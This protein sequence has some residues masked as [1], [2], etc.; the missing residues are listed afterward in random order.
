MPPELAPAT[1]GFRVHSGWAAVVAVSGSLTAPAV[2]GRWRIEMATPEIPGSKQPYHAAE[3]LELQEAEQFLL[4]CTNS[5]VSLAR[6][7]IGDCIH[8][9]NAKD[10]PVS[11]CGVLFA[12]RRPLG[13]LA[14]ILASHALIH[15]AEGEFFRN[16]VMDACEHHG[17]QVMAVKEKE[18]LFR[19]LDKLQISQEALDRLLSSIGR[20]I[21]PPWRQDEKLAVLVAWLALAAA[22]GTS[23]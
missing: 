15:S 22:G 18:L 12:S 6:T 23:N 10:L 11:H 7:A 3:N 16:V 5:S 21:G 1:L 13:I 8:E 19:S 4:R 9:V 14:A 20:T 17:L 2:M